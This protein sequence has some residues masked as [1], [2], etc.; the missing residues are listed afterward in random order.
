MKDKNQNESFSDI[1]LVKL[2]KKASSTQEKLQYFSKLQDANCQME[3][4]NSIPSNERYKFIGKI[5][6]MQGIA[7]ALNALEDDKTKT[8]TFNFIAKQFKGNNEGLLRIL[9]QVDFDVEIPKNMLTFQLNNIN[10]LNLDFLINIQKHTINHSEMK[11]KINEYQSDSTKIEYSF[12]EISAIVAKVEELTADIPRDMDEANK[13]YKLYSRITG[14]MTYDYNCIWQQDAARNKADKSRAGSFFEWQK[15]QEQYAKEMKEIRKKP[16]GL[17]GGLVDGKAICA[18]YALILHEALRYVGMK[19]QYVIGFVPGSAGH[20]W[21][22]VQID[23]RWYNADST[24]DSQE[25]QIY[26]RYENMLLNDE[27]FN[28]THGKFSSRRTKTEHQ[29]KSR[30]DY[31]KIQGLLPSQIKSTGRREHSL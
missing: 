27:D 12:S 11:F 23:G 8:Q 7:I 17:Y 31:S 21:N 20:A 19:S 4:L 15:A 25:Y 16:A 9:T 22:Q 28:K 29:C 5:K 18:G 6:S 1:E 13:F 2:F 3:L 24:W 26:R 30:F 14:M 10:A